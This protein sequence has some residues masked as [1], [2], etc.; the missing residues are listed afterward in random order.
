MRIYKG[1]RVDFFIGRSRHEFHWKPYECPH[2]SSIADVK[3]IGDENCAELYEANH[4][5]MAHFV[6]FFWLFW[7][8]SIEIKRQKLSSSKFVRYE[9]THYAAIEDALTTKP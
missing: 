4:Y 1:K 8:F 6:Q 9:A 5:W 3:Y 7:I 2:I